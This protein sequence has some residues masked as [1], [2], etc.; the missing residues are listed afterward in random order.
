MGTKLALQWSETGREDDIA[1]VSR[2]FSALENIYNVD[3]DADELYSAANIA[4]Y[5][6]APTEQG[7]SGRYVVDM[8]GDTEE[9]YREI[10]VY[11]MAGSDLVESDLLEVIGHGVVYWDGTDVLPID[12]AAGSGATAAEVWAHGDRTLTGTSPRVT[13]TGA[14][15][16]AQN[17]ELVRGD[18]YLDANGRALSFTFAGMPSLVGASV[19]F[20]VYDIDEQEATISALAGVVVSATVAKFELPRALTDL[21]TPSDI[22]YRFDMQATLASGARVTYTRGKAVVLADYTRD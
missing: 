18:D 7:D 10:T 5:R 21:L 2:P 17:I 14:V 6:I 1:F 15:L 3:D 19:V 13:V 8:P 11:E 16:D 12:D 9:G 20:S 4:D 22:R